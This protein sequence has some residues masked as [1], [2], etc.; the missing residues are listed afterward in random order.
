[1]LKSLIGLGLGVV[2]FSGCG[3]NIDPD[4]PKCYKD[5]DDKKVEVGQWI[6]DA[7]SFFVRQGINDAFSETVSPKEG[8]RA[9]WDQEVARLKINIAYVDNILNPIEKDVALLAEKRHIDTTS[10]AE[11]FKKLVTTFHTYKTVLNSKFLAGHYQG[12]L[13]HYAYHY[14]N[15]VFLLKIVDGLLEATQEFIRTMPNMSIAEQKLYI[16]GVTLGRKHVLE[17][18]RAKM[19]RKPI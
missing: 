18:Y 4:L 10:S 17:R 8:E 13:K 12:S 1:M 5:V 2:I 6:C 19:A 7:D 11:A 15:D 14:P 3:Y 16:D 9:H